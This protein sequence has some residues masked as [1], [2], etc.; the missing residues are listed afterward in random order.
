[1]HAIALALAHIDGDPFHQFGL[2]LARASSRQIVADALGSCPSG[3][4]RVLQCLPA[5]VLEPED[6]RNLVTLLNDPKTAKLLHHADQID[7]SAIRLLRDLPT[8]L[9]HLAQF[10]F[11]GRIGS[12]D[13]FTDA[14]QF[15]VDRGA[16]F[17][18]DALV[19]DLGSVNRPG[20]LIT[21]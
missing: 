10:V 16:A 12:L 6:Y 21:K 14:L 13:G 9:V 20:Q 3:I 8:A 17:S 5:S 15:L 4:A 11:D 7:D 18:F 2:L 1:M 19:A